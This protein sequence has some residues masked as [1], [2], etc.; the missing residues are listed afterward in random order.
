MDVFFMA[1][2]Y[3]K[4]IQ[5]A[6]ARPVTIIFLHEALG[7]VEMWGDFPEKLCALTKCNGLVYDRFGFGLSDESFTNKNDNYLFDSALELN[8]IIQKNIKGQYILYGH[9][10]GGT[11][12]LIHATQNN[13]KLLGIITEA[14]HVLVEKVT[15]IGIKK[16]VEAFQKGKLNGLKKFHGTKTN[17]IFNSWS[18]VWLRESFKE[19]NIENILSNI[20]I[21]NLI[22]QGVNDQY[23]TIYQADQIASLTLGDSIKYTPLCGHSP[24]KELPSAVLN[25]V[26]LFIKKI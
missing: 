13:S 26:Q 19:W 23:A 18:E 16:A 12:A 17:Q 4:H 14:A 9:S 7:C 11:I 25:K 5:I 24:F 3:V 21:P 2:L 10:D 8:Q 22:I 20:T 1:N 15:I 6:D